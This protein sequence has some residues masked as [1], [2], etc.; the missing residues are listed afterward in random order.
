MANTLGNLISGVKTRLSN[1]ISNDDD[2]EKNKIKLKTSSN[3]SRTYTPI[4][5]NNNLISNKTSSPVGN[6]TQGFNTFKQQQSQQ[7]QNTFQNN[8]NFTRNILSKT[9]ATP[10][11]QKIAV[12]TPTQ[13]TLGEK[14]QAGVNRVKTMVKND[15][16]KLLFNRAV[17][18][19]PQSFKTVGKGLGNEQIGEDIGYGVRGAYNLTGINAINKYGLGGKNTQAIDQANIPTTERQQRAEDLGQAIYGNV[20]AAGFSAGQPAMQVAGGLLKRGAAGTTLGLA[21][22]TASA[23]TQGRLPTAEELKEGGVSGLENSW[24]LAFSNA[25]TD[26]VLSKI[27]FTSSLTDDA[28]KNTLQTLGKTGDKATKLSLLK[29][30]LKNIFLRN[31]AEVPA[32]NTMMTLIDELDG[33]AQESLIQEWANNLPGTILGNIVFGAAE[34]AARGT[35]N[36]NKADVDVAK[37]VL[38]KTFSKFF[39]GSLASQAGKIT[40]GNANKAQAKETFNADTISQVTKNSLLNNPENTLLKPNRLDGENFSFK[41]A[42]TGLAE[43]GKDLSGRIVIGKDDN[44]EVILKDGTHLLDAYR[45]KGIEIPN[46]KI[47]LEDGVTNNDLMA[48]QEETP[49]T[50]MQDSINDYVKQ[51]K[52]VEDE[53]QMADVKAVEESLN[54]NKFNKSPDGNLE[55]T[56]EVQNSLNQL[57]YMID[58]NPRII[59]KLSGDTIQ[60]LEENNMQVEGPDGTL[61]EAGK[62]QQEYRFQE[63]NGVTPALTQEVTLDNSNAKLEENTIKDAGVAETGQ[64]TKV[65]EEDVPSGVT[66]ATQKELDQ[67]GGTPKD[68]VK[69]TVSESSKAEESQLITPEMYQRAME[70]MASL[71]PAGEKLALPAGTV[72][73]KTRNQAL[74]ALRNL[75][76]EAKIEVFNKLQ[77]RMT[78]IAIA[79]PG[80]PFVVNTAEQARRILAKY[81]EANVEIAK[82]VLPNGNKPI[83]SIIYDAPQ[84]GA[85]TA[86]VNSRK[87][88]L[89]ALGIPGKT[90]IVDNPLKPNTDPVVLLTDAQVET[91]LSKNTIGGIEKLLYGSETSNTANFGGNKEGAGF[92]S[93]KVRALQENASSV[94]GDWTTS[95]SGV[96]RNFARVLQGFSG[97]LGKTS[98]DVTRKGKYDGGI[99][100]SAQIAADTQQ[101]VYDLVG[102][103]YSSLEKIHAVLDPD[104]AK[105]KVDFDS[106][107]DKEKEAVGVLRTMSDYINDTNYKN[108]FISEEN[109]LKNRGGKYIARGYEKYEYPEEVSSLLKRANGKLELDPFRKRGEIEDWKKED[110]VRDP[111]YLVAKRLQQTLFNDTVVKMS[112]ELVKNKNYVSDVEKSGF[113]KVSDHK[114]YGEL[115]GKYIR[116]D[117]MDD[118]KGFFFTHEAAQKMYDVL[119]WYD[120]NPLRTAQKKLLTV[121]NPAVQLGNKTGNYVFAWLNGINP[122]TFTK[123][124]A[125][126]G[127]AIKNKDELVRLMTKEGLLGTDITKAD[128]VKM[129]VELQASVKADGKVK[130][131]DN[132]IKKIN[133]SVT[134]HYTKTDDVAKIAAMKTWLDRGFTWEEAAKRVYSGFQ[135]YRTVGWLYDVGAKVPVLGNPFVR[136]KADLGRILKN[137][138]VDHPFRLAMTL[139]AWSMFTKG[140]SAMSGETEEDKETRESRIGASRIPFTD[141]SLEVQTPWGALNAGRLIGPQAFNQPGDNSVTGDISDFGPIAF[142]KVSN[143]TGNLYGFNDPVL[144]PVASLLTD[145]D[146]RG[147]PISDPNSNKY[148]GSLATSEQKAENRLKYLGESFS[149]PGTD[150]IG[151]LTK[152]I[153]GETDYYGRTFTPKQAIA[154]LFGL[155]VEEYGPEQAREQREKDISYKINA[156]DSV[157]KDI[158]TIYNQLSDGKIDEKAA[159]EQVTAKQEQLDKLKT[160]INGAKINASQESGTVSGVSAIDKTEKKRIETFIEN[161][162]EVS[163]QDLLNYYGGDLSTMPESTPVEK[164]KKQEAAFKIVD[165]VL[166]NKDLSEDKKGLI[167]NN[168]GIEPEDAQYYLDAKESQQ[169][170]FAQVTSVLDGMEDADKVF[171]TLLGFLREVNGQAILTSG[172]ITDLYESG[173]ITKE[174][175]KQLGNYRFNPVTGKVE[176]TKSSL[177]G[178][179]PKKISI[180]FPNIS[181]P[182]MNLPAIKMGSGDSNL[183]RLSTNNQSISVPDTLKP[184]LV[185]TKTS[186][187]SNDNL[188]P[189]LRTPVRNLSGLGRG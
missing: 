104:L 134:S 168:L 171:D 74:Q 189:R 33:D 64:T 84:I 95:N 132:V 182:K 71:L 123:N 34:G 51:Q 167:L 44:G 76:P 29:T 141:I 122:I 117:M 85:G 165:E 49:E 146:F 69:G 188:T 98:E 5:L 133:E 35:W 147:K 2:D 159:I 57:S 86:V 176:K 91:M 80:T 139:G 38:Q 21:M 107:N 152:S 172:L 177:E 24:Q 32:E 102:K 83:E 151:R 90:I 48:K 79:P 121:F 67:M 30:G 52:Q 125:W 92:F 93:N 108:G 19:A 10:A 157:Q 166:E 155:K 39:D 41:E 43:N 113:V 128:I 175:K 140:M 164:M 89:E 131:K 137:A 4:K 66:G 65:G 101:H 160:E 126:A 148:T 72:Q 174:M 138:A 99:A 25:I 97:G 163:D 40:L 116:K 178:S 127:Q 158:S 3:Q 130:N 136:F 183:I 124:K 62:A 27:K 161:G 9:Q 150:D 13:P 45:Q 94:V 50:V 118:I 184:N 145:T 20:L 73:I 54:S 22:T 16:G 154:R 7:Q 169:V 170:K 144:G 106:L 162:I 55:S 186:G 46:N 11:S 70:D 96:L 100:Y 149:P 119:N 135:N 109:W 60:K 105:E 111:A 180:D 143:K 185:S 56:A 112:N 36:F 110:A 26:K 103:D 18:Q 181:T 87:Q 88:A 1:F 120:R 75:S 114:A 78:P 115:A 28:I 37:D 63:E 142:P 77:G 82:N 17:A 14:F 187:S 68:A 173:Y 6:F 156:V 61:K 129:A 12:K 42:E 23:L 31:L 81:P 179:K 8:L 47:K 15:P 53:A 153:N 58:E 59:T